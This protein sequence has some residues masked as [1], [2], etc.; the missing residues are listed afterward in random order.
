MRELTSTERS[1]VEAIVGGIQ[2][3]NRRRHQ[4][5]RSGWAFLVTGALAL[6]VIAAAMDD[7][8]SLNTAVLRIGVALAL[9]M[10]VS[11]AIGSMLDSYQ[12]AAALQSVEDALLK[13]RAESGN[14]PASPSAPTPASPADP[15]PLDTRE[16]VAD[17]PSADQ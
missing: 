4:A 3:R 6:P 9:S 8:I 2:R 14:S 13:A 16:V 12:N 11:L 17:D 15:G 1:T 5:A 10:F 7:A